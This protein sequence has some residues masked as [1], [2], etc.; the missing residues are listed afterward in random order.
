M[1]KQLC[2]VLDMVY[3]KEWRSLRPQEKDETAKHDEQPEK[4]N[5][6]GS[7]RVYTDADVFADFMS[8][9][10]KLQESVDEKEF[11]LNLPTHTYAKRAKKL[12]EGMSLCRCRNPIRRKARAPTEHVIENG[13]L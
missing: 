9:F 12:F 8:V 10:D 5:D 13:A 11:G 7:F 2:A 4:Q 1:L 6:T 3:A